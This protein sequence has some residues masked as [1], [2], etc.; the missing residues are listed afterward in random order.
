M[1]RLRIRE[2]DCQDLEKFRRI[3]NE[4]KDLVVEKGGRRRTD[5]RRKDICE[6]M[7]QCGRKEILENDAVVKLPRLF[8]ILHFV[9]IIIKIIDLD[10]A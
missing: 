10:M 3:A 4:G 1:P 5:E 7:G 8:R 2:K 9:I 6:K